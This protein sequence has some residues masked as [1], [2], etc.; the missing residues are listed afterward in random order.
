VKKLFT[1][2]A[3][4]LL[5]SLA[6]GRVDADD[7]GFRS[8]VFEPA[9]E[10][11]DFELDGS[12]GAKIKLS[13]LRGKVVILQFGFSYCPKIC[14]VTL[15][16]VT[17]AFK[18]LGPA[19]AGVQ[20][21]FITVDPERDSPA[22]LKEFLSFFNPTFLGATGSEETLDAVNKAYGVLANKAASTDKKL[23]YEVHH[24]SSIY[25]VDRQGMLR[26]LVPFGKSPDAIA[27]D[28]TLLL[29]K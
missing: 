25:L 16:N 8:G 9:R 13:A 6:P 21:V 24:S 11:P 27:H 15:A 22:R 14:P 1:L 12:E 29:K 2:V 5:V 28:I 19:A 4:T 7:D 3:A 20:H 23:G 10:A 26:V 17:E 18:L